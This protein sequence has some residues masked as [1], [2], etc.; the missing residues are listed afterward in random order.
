MSHGAAQYNC[1]LMS[2]P[3]EIAFDN[4]KQAQSF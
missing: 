1:S 4:Q 3:N 2:K